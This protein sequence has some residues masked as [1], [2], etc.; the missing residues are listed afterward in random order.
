VQRKRP[1][2]GDVGSAKFATWYGHG[3]SA[4]LDTYLPGVITERSGTPS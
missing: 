4:A 2:R 1:Q 3:R